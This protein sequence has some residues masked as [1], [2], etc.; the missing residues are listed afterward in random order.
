MLRRALFGFILLSLGCG[1][2]DALT[3]T[4]S[5]AGGGGGGSVCSLEPPAMPASLEMCERIPA[6]VS[7]DGMP[8]LA[9]AHASVRLFSVAP[10]PGEVDAALV[11]ALEGRPD[12]SAYAAALPG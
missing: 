6:G 3:T 8:E 7:V 5:G 11:A 4:S 1:E 9:A 2:D 12:M 10:T